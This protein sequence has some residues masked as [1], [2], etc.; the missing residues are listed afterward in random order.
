MTTQQRPPLDGDEKLARLALYLGLQTNAA[1]F[2]RVLRQTG[3]AVEAFDGRDL[4]VL[5]V[6]LR[7]LFSAGLFEEAQ[8]RLE[9]ARQKG[10]RILFWEDEDYP[11]RLDEIPDPPPVLW[12]QGTLEAEDQFAVSLVGSREA[13]RPGL[14]AARRLAREGA[15]MGLTI[16]SGLARGI[17]A[18]A[19]QGALEAGGRTLAVLGSGLDWVYPKENAGLYQEIARHGALIS[20]FPPEVRPL[21]AHFPRRNRVVAGLGLAVVVVEAGQR[22]GALITARLALEL[23]REV[24]ALPGPAGAASARGAHGLI[25][26]GA[27]LVES[28]AEVLVEIKPRLLEGLAAPAPESLPALEPLAGEPPAESLDEEARPAASEPP[29]PARSRKTVRRPADPPENPKPSPDLTG[30]PPD[31]PEAQILAQLA[32]GP[33]DADSLARALGLN[34]ADLSLLMLNLELS[35]RVER[36]ESGWFGLAAG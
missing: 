14:T 5:G 29:R 31:G 21:P 20:E 35:G 16:V 13:S 6:N 2:H 33:R 3:R 18:Q 28:M 25:K 11:A 26:S 32:R 9:E 7:P 24:M 19:H 8:A 34:P 15:R 30:L 12:I 17:D 4:T 10:R 36:L 27:A 22:S 23:N 1:A